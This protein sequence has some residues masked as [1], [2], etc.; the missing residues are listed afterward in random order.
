MNV[1]LAEIKMDPAIH[2]RERLYEDTIQSYMD[3]FDKLP[4]IVLFRTKEGLLLADGFHRVAAA[5]RLGIATIDAEI[6]EGTREEA[7]E[8]AS[9]ANAKHGRPLTTEER[10]A[11][12]GRLRLL[13]PDWD[14]GRVAK[15]LSCSE[16]LI[17]NTLRANEVRKSL[18]RPTPLSESHLEAISRA[19]KELWPTLAEAAEKQDWSRDETR[20]V[21][22]EV[23][24][25]SVPMERKKELL[26]GRAHPLV[27]RGEEPAILPETLGRLIAQERER[28]FAAFL[29]GALEQLAKL[30]RFSAKEVVDGLDEHALDRIGKELP[31]YIDFQQEI[32]SLARQKLEIW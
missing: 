30:R 6:K 12:I 2:I 25:D 13:H 3:A 22:Q 5:D 17:A 19:D 10:R 15:L 8:Y 20:A 31:G 4:P 14:Y 28:N 32:L 16:R 1:R 29:Y 21:V 7:L 24:D 9:Y 11:A 26:E 23:K 18:A 27:K